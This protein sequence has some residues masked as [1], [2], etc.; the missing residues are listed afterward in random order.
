PKTAVE[1][2]MEVWFATWSQALSAFPAAPA[3][4]TSHVPSP[5]PSSRPTAV[6][7]TAPET[8]LASTWAG[9]ACRVSAVTGRQISPSSTRSAVLNLLRGSLRLLVVPGGVPF[10]LPVDPDVVVA[11]D[12]LPRTGRV[13]RARPEMVAPDRVGRE[14][15]IAFDDD[16]AVAL[17]EY[18][19]VPDRSRHVTLR[20]WT[21]PCR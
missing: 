15:L 9:S 4:S 20:R 11:C 18:G 7:S 10:H 12:D 13:R 1:A 16:A 6:R 8:A 3:R 17:G 2:P 19:P 5:G 21:A 14:V